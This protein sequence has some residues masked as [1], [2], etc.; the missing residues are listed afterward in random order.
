MVV[1]GLV[2]YATAAASREIWKYQRSALLRNEQA[3]R[4][5]AAE[6]GSMFFTGDH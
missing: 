6:S 4:W 3:C 2:S 1:D 5:S